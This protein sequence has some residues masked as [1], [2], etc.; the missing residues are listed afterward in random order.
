MMCHDVQARL[1]DIVSGSLA[2][3]E[4]A[5]CEQHIAR[6]M[7]CGEARLGAQGLAALSRRAP[8]AVP[9]ELFGTI[10]SRLDVADERV[11]GRGRFWTG[12]GAGAAMTASLFALALTLGWVEVP[13]QDPAPAETEFMVTLSEPRDLNVAIETE[14][15]LLN[16]NITVMLTGGVELT[17]YT[18]QRELSWNADLAAGINRLTLPVRAIDGDGGRMIVRLRHPDSEQVLVVRVKADV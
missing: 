12:T 3:T 18:G 16:A 2:P 8:G 15:A 9:P 4:L 1:A 14:R 17:G 13:R 11:P 5:D 6:C 10:V 7:D